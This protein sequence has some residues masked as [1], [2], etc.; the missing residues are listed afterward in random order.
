M[1]KFTYQPLSYGVVFDQPTPQTLL[2]LLGFGW[3]YLADRSR[4]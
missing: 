4:L 1:L 3:R 2:A